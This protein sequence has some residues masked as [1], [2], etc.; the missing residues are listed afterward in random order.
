MFLEEQDEIPW[1]SLVYVT[2]Q[3][4]YGGRITDDQ[5]RRCLMTILANYYSPSIIEDDYKF[6][7]SGTYY[8]PEEGSL[9]SYVDYT[10][11]LPMEEAPEVFGMH[12]NA[13]IAFDLA[14]S[15]KIVDTVLSIQPRVRTAGGDSD[16][17]GPEQIVAELAAEMERTMPLD[18]PL[19]TQTELCCPGLFDRDPE[20][21]QMDSLAT[22]LSQEVDRFN[23]L[24]AVLRSSLVELQ[25]A[26]RGLIVMSGDLEEMFAAFLNNQVPPKWTSA[27]YPSLKPLAS[28]TSD[29]QA[30]M[31]FMH[32]WTKEGP[33]KSFSLPSI[34][35][36]QGFLTGMLQKHARKHIIP[37]DSLEYAFAVTE[38]NE[39]EEVEQAAEDGCY[40]HGLFVEA[41]T[42]DEES[43]Q[44]QPALPGAMYA[45]LPL[46]H[47][48]PRPVGNHQDGD[49]GTG[50]AYQYEC[51]L[52]R[53]SVRKGVLTTTG[54]SSNYVLD[55]R[56]PI[57][58][59]PSFFILQGTAALC[60]LAD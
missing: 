3:I 41:A 46:V 5:D 55:I 47:F 13:L 38:F 12:N 11:A 48:L 8:V 26:I 53:T 39:A 33:P 45:S 6:S 10:R 51:P 1:E 22:V 37:I 32:A 36:T 24:M 60:S 27:A 49:E 30:R 23:G 35:F 20:T 25:R 2:G 21:G 40:V 19:P 18:L 54:A 58:R 15:N 57:G 52:Y 50:T 34:F 29:L 44:L 59:D 9:Q 31:A 16:E 43:K 7:E 42:W 4:N 14:E 17:A 28:W 56:L